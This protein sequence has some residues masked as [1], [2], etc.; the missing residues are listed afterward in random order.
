MLF[1]SSP[2]GNA[3]FGR[4]AQRLQWFQRRLA[5]FG[6]L[7]GFERK[8]LGKILVR[9]QFWLVLALIRRPA[10]LSGSDENSENERLRIPEPFIFFGATNWL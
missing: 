8:Q 2:T 3:V 5:Q 9:Q 1:R 10:A 4:R 6:G 7:F